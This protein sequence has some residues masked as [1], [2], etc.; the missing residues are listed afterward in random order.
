MEGGVWTWRIK[1]KGEVKGEQNKNVIQIVCNVTAVQSR[2]YQSP[3]TCCSVL[4]QHQLLL[5]LLKLLIL[6]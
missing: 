1:K 4:V 2:F 3:Y 6:F 5:L